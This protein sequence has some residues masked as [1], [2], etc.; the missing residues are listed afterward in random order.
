MK[1]NPEKAPEILLI[2]AKNNT[3]KT[4]MIH[5]SSAKNGTEREHEVSAKNTTATTLA[6]LLQILLSCTKTTTLGARDIPL[7]L[8]KG[9]GDGSPRFF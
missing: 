7:F 8:P 5:L 4:L 6:I 3:E 1:D 2:S 9:T